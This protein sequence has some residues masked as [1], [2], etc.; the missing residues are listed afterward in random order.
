MPN[1]GETQWGN[2]EFKESVRSFETAFSKAKIQQESELE[3]IV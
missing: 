3:W 2:S 1:E